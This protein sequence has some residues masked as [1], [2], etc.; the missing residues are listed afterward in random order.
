MKRFALIASL[1]V[2]SATEAATAAVTVIG[3][4]SARLCYEAAR[5][6][7]TAGMAYCDAAFKDEALDPHN[8]VA[9]YV[10][11]GILR[12]I[13]GDLTAAVRD[14][15]AAIALDA[16]EPEAWLNKAMLYLKTGNAAGALGL[17][18]AAVAKRTQEPAMAFYGRGVAHEQVGNLRAAYADFKRAS[19]LV[20]D[21]E[22]P[23]V[24]LSRFQVRPASGGTPR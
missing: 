16:N 20:P 19:A 14:Y 7:R 5:A 18:D 1:A 10:N 22:A 24:E 9:T 23:K 6:S 4:S 2:L 8:E 12:A 15:D 17:F 11:R 21:W 13:G 3:S